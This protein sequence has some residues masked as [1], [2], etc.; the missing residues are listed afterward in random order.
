MATEMR[1][2]GTLAD[3]D[4]VDIVNA[5]NA[6]TNGLHTVMASN[7]DTMIGIKRGTV[8]SNFSAL[9]ESIE[10]YME[11]NDFEKDNWKSGVDLV[12]MR[13]VLTKIAAGFRTISYNKKFGRSIG[14]ASADVMYILEGRD[15]I[16]DPPKNQTFSNLEHL[17]GIMDDIRTCCLTSITKWSTVMERVYG[18]VPLPCAPTDILSEKTAATE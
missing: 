5:L 9:A 10:S 18:I 3:Q 14:P 4:T 11:G 12:K 15:N 13:D 2:I 16:F 1:K 7:S 8:L 6:I 17:T